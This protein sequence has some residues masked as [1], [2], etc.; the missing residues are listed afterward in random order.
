M[1]EPSCCIKWGWRLQQPFQQ[2]VAVMCPQTVHRCSQSNSLL[3]L[4][5]LCEEYN[6]TR[7]SGSP[8]YTPTLCL[9]MPYPWFTPRN[10]HTSLICYWTHPS[11]NTI[12][13]WINSRALL[14]TSKLNCPSYVTL[15]KYPRPTSSHLHRHIYS[16]STH[17]A[18]HAHMSKLIVHWEICCWYWITYLVMYSNDWYLERIQLPSG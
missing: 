8:L 18:F 15:S 12:Y 3:M 2:W 13:I 9:P 4:S 6:M 7:E 5:L 11:H 1:R 10:I 17:T 14:H 16:L